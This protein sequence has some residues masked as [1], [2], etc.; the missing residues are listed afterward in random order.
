MEHSARPSRLPWLE[1][2]PRTASAEL[3]GTLAMPRSPLPSHNRT[4]L[5]RRWRQRDVSTRPVRLV[6]R[7]HVRLA[8]HSDA[9]HRV[10]QPW[11]CTNA[12]RVG[13]WRLNGHHLRRTRAFTRRSRA[14]CAAPNGSPATSLRALGSSHRKPAAQ[15]SRSA[16]IVETCCISLPAHAAPVG[17]PDADRDLRLVHVQ[18]RTALH[19]LPHPR[20]SRIEN[21]GCPRRAVFSLRPTQAALER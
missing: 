2:G 14:P 18:R 11:S 6:S 3:A 4:R 17:R 10:M 19:A 16:V 7:G 1:P 21:N 12:G 9:L 15:S 13:R 20:L 5:A 8:F